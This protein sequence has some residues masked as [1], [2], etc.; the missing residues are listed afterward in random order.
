MLGFNR[1]FLYI[2]GKV[3]P[4]ELYLQ[5]IP[6]ITFICYVC[7]HMD[8]HVGQRTAVGSSGLREH[9][10]LLGHLGGHLPFGSNQKWISLGLISHKYS[11]SMGELK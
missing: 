11:P 5:H 4:T 2:G 3:P 10:Y 6:L 8:M 9:L 7:V 1:R